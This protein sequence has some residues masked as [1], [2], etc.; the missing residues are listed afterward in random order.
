MALVGEGGRQTV[1]L[2][3]ARKGLGP[4]QR[5]ALAAWASDAYWTDLAA[6]G[7]VRSGK[8]ACMVAGFG[9]W[10]VARGGEYVVGSRSVAS[11]RR[12]LQPEFQ[13]VADYLGDGMVDALR[14]ERGEG[15][16]DIGG[17]I[18]H[19][20]GAPNKQ[21]QDAVQGLTAS[22]AL[23]DETTLLPIN[24]VQQA[25]SRCSE[26]GSRVGMLMNPE[27]PNH[28][29]K[30]EVIDPG[31]ANGTLLYRHFTLDDNPTLTEERKEFY[32]GTFSGVFYRRNILGEWC[33]AE[34]AIWPGAVYVTGVP[35]SV[36][37]A[38]CGMDLGMSGTTAGVVAGIGPKG[39]IACDEYSYRV[40]RD[41]RER[42][43]R[44]H[45]VHVWEMA[46]S[47]G[48]P[49][50][51]VD[52]TAYGVLAAD[53]RELGIPISRQRGGVLPGIATIGEAFTHGRLVVCRDAC[54]RTVESISGYVWDPAAQERGLDAALK[55]DDH[56]C[57]ALRY[58]VFPAIKRS[59]AG[60]VAIPAGF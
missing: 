58:A 60:V 46:Q 53:A 55:V 8:G 45:L 59:D 44:E 18:F 2:R 30:R 1:S 24:F 40:G 25:R 10:A 43:A 41:G 37:S 35:D 14:D 34:G 38:R 22:G 57:D 7:S 32:R 19:V 29:V 28:P 11:A 20:F 3:E 23:L 33:A 56:E 47:W 9:L 48:C 21:S 12:N 54:P 26:P 50:V 17:T 31:L 6:V 36:R 42:S 4:A 49:R 51:I 15:Y 5:F 52:R 39:W 13:A 16:W 27:S